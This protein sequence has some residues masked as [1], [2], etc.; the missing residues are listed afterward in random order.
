MVIAEHD[1]G[2]FE[3]AMDDAHVV[4][5]GDAATDLDHDLEALALG[6]FA[7]FA[8]GALGQVLEHHVEAFVEGAVLE[9]LDDVGMAQ[10]ADH[11]GL[12]GQA[13]AHG[14]VAAVLG[15]QHL[16][17]RILIALQAGGQ[18]DLGGS[19][20]ADFFQDLETRDVEQIIPLS[21]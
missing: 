2:G 19:A 1:V 18:P 17:C 21:W 13:A 20:L 5:E 6:E 9:D 3:I 14:G 10:L 16:Q 12:A 15:V 8:E 4:D 11:V 7:V